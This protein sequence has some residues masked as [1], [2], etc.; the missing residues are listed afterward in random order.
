MND[1]SYSEI[2]SMQKRAMERVR[3][4]QRNSDSV[5]ENA[6]TELEN[7]SPREQIG[8]LPNPSPALGQTPVRPKVTNMP[9][10]FPRERRREEQNLPERAEPRGKDKDGGLIESILNEP[11]RAMLLGLLLL[12]KS[13]GADEALMMALMYIMS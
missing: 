11:D 6:R 2:Q 7:G 4:M 1:Y 3:E 10:N 12:L 5:L 13:E 9:A 8:F